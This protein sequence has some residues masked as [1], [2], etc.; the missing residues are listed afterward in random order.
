MLSIVFSSRISSAT[1]ILWF[2][3]YT[4]HKNV[5]NQVVEL[6]VSYP[7]L[8]HFYVATI[9]FALYAVN[10]KIMTRFYSKYPLNNKFM[11][12]TVKLKVEEQK[13]ANVSSRILCSYNNFQTIRTIK[14]MFISISQ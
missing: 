5:S 11:T 4:L 6:K 14:R 7:F 9:V 12:K 8:R 2:I 3:C 13:I 1:N 10:A